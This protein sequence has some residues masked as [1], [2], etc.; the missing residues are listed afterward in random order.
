MIK[1]AITKSSGEVCISE[2]ISFNDVMNIQAE[3]MQAWYKEES[4]NL[5]RCY[6]NDAADNEEVQE[7]VIADALNETEYSTIE[8][9]V[10]AIYYANERIDELAKENEEMYSTLN[11]IYHTV[12][13]YD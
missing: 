13:E 7:R 8:E 10:E 12:R 3:I 11:D 1:V 9:V 5:R 6:I 2:I 4:E